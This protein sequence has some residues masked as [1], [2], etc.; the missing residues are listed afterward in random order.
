[1]KFKVLAVWLMMLIL[2][3]SASVFAEGVD[4]GSFVRDGVGARAFGFGGSFTAIADDASATFWNPAGIAQ[5]EGINLSAMHT[6]RFGL[7][8]SFQF[9]SSTVQLNNFGLGLSLVRSSIDDIPYYGDEGDGVFSET[10]TLILGSIGYDPGALFG[11]LD[12]GVP[13]NL[14][15]GLNGKIYTHSILDGSAQ[16]FGFDVGVL[17]DFTF[18]WGELSFGYVSKDV[19][20][21][22]IQWEGTDFNPTNDVPWIHRFGMA[23]SLFEE[24]ALVTAEVEFAPQRAHLNRVHAGIEY[25]IVKQFGVRVGATLSEGT[26]RVTYGGT[27]A[28]AGFSFD[29]A[30]VTHPALGATHVFSLV[31]SI[32]TWWGSDETE[33]IENDGSTDVEGAEGLEPKN[34]EADEES[35]GETN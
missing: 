24:S 34:D 20:G 21:T 18:E 7:G 31:Y 1:M 32:P 28:Y 14:Y 19:T 15:V 10:Q 11:D 26:A 25:W 6:N 30:Y 35:V 16:G 17:G 2:S 4:A 3:A 8:I 29:Y 5:L 33:T 22:Q 23:A 12:F 27:V 9:L 13:F